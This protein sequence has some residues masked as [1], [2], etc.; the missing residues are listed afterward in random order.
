MRL[1]S[2]KIV[3]SA[4][5]LKFEAMIFALRLLRLKRAFGGWRA[6]SAVLRFVRREAY[7]FDGV[8]G[9]PVRYS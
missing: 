1:L 4:V 5:A 2:A 3:D 7:Q 8:E 6:V 9:T